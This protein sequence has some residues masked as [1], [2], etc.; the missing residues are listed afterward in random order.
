MCNK[1]SY[2]NLVAH[3][4]LHNGVLLIVFLTY[5]EYRK[6]SIRS[7]LSIILDLNFPRIVLEVV[8]KHFRA[9]IF[10]EVLKDPLRTLKRPK[11]IIFLTLEGVSLLYRPT[12]N[13]RFTVSLLWRFAITSVH[14]YITDLKFVFLLPLFKIL[15]VV[16]L[17]V[18]LDTDELL[19]LS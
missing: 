9:N 16:V 8:Q 11:N 18:V 19:V 10:I 14:T 2:V 15:K 7:R 4:Y 5:A 3:V 1:T 13:W 12:S 17:S 6:S